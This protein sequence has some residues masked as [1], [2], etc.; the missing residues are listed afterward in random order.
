L[1]ALGF[2][3]LAAQLARADADGPQVTTPTGMTITPT[4]ARGARFVTL[5]P[6]LP[7][8][9]GFLAD[10]AAALALSPDGKT[11]LILTSGFNRNNDAQG[12]RAQQLSNEYVFVYDVTAE[13]PVKRQVLQIPNSFLGLAW[14]PSGERFYVSGGVNDDVVEFTRSGSGFAV[15]RTFALGHKAGLGID[16]KPMA[17]GLALSPNGKRLLVAN[18][19]NDSVSL[20]DLDAGAVIAEQDLRPGKLDASQRGK[21]GGTFPRAIV[22]ASDA[23]AYVASERDRE[24]IVLAVESGRVVPGRRIAT[25]GQP[26]A[27]AV[28]AGGARLLAALSNTDGLAI[29]GTHTD[30][31]RETIDTSAPNALMDRVADLGGANSDA[32]A[33]LPD[34]RTV[35]V[36]NGG[37]NAVA[38]VRLGDRQRGEGTPS[39]VV[40][41]IPTGWYPTAVA[42]SAD[43][44][45]FFVVNGKSPPGPNPRACRNSLQLYKQG[46]CV[47]SN[48]YVW[49]LEKAGFLTLPAPG[50]EELARLTRQVALNDGFIP[51]ADAARDRE[52]MAFLHAHIR[53]VLFIIKENRTYDQVLG[54]LRPGD[55]DTA[56]NI[57]PRALAPNHHALASRFVTL[58][59]FFD[60]G[61]SS[62]TGWQ[63][64]TAARTTEFTEAEAPVDYAGRGLT[65]DQEGDN[66]DINVGLPFAERRAL[67]QQTPD[68]P[69]ILA[70]D[71]DVAAPDGPG[72]AAG[73][74][75]LWDAALKAGLTIRNWGFFGDLSRYFGKRDDLIPLER[76]P[77][78]AGLK[79]FWTTK[80]A[81]APVTDPYYRG[82]DQAFPDYWRFKEWER[83][84]D[85]MDASGKA[86]SLMLM[87]LAKDHFGD[88]QRAIDGIDTVET[89]MADNDYALGLVVQKIA[90]SKF[91]S[92]TLIFVI[93]D[94]AQDGPDHVDAHR[95]IAFV[96]GPY[97]K[98]G[99]VVST[100]FTTVSVVRTI[101][102]VLGIGP[103][104]LNDALARPMTDVFDRTQAHWTF[105]PE[106]PAVL[107]S[108]KLP[109]PPP[110]TAQAAY[111]RRTSA[112]WA[113]AMA[114]QDFRGEDRLDT[115]DFNRALWRGLKGDETPYPSG[116]RRQGHASQD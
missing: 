46:D 9:P 8:L 39:R 68:D 103:M 61:E 7:G 56:L 74:G 96:A 31:V 3:T 112:W 16:A 109:L 116:L 108:T 102:G 65:F 30:Q 12:K 43:G 27:L 36:S 99:K 104:G 95:S 66:R 87:R 80:P 90:H 13:T 1:L 101:E 81:L 71:E 33:I 63:W 38:V 106:V 76:D 15:A 79:V 73:H 113:A 110:R 105:E 4:A 49:Q 85:A 48:Q 5:N 97:V 50:P 93:E 115:T 44:K 55:G 59:R 45:R 114:G 67:N 77:F 52:M 89:E 54:D 26:T 17:A 72:G 10:H 20:I 28:D 111:P 14:A 88:F 47:A 42:A 94:D 40:G 21:P 75:Y 19:Q 64:S 32:L 70:G 98:Q 2:A 37:E 82:F 41:L 91:A 83:E 11:L 107:R 92:D 23:K 29:I 22:W 86:P 57:F 78:K 58:D 69:D 34:N 84:F 62:N 6:D 60:S 35:L 25:A 24:I 100:P 53:H 51:A 18:Y